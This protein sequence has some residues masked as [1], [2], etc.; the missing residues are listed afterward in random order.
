MVAA[1]PSRVDFHN[2]PGALYT[3][4]TGDATERDIPVFLAPMP[5]AGPRKLQPRAAPGG[6]SI[7]ESLAITSTSNPLI[8]SRPLSL[9]L[10]THLLKMLAPILRRQLLQSTRHSRCFS[11]TPIG[12]AQEVKRLGVIGAGQMV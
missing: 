6:L 5:T 8:F 7:S 12:S 4:L 10:F 1:C 2:F 3:L 9:A 11:S